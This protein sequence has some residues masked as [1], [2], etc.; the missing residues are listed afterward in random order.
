VAGSR[1][2]DYR[3]I[4]S[5]S[6]SND[7][8]LDLDDIFGCL[9]KNAKSVQRTSFHLLTNINPSS[10]LFKTILFNL[11]KLSELLKTYYRV[12]LAILTFLLSCEISTK[13]KIFWGEVYDP[14]TQDY[15]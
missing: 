14:P 10:R 1:N 11:S 4:L 15:P 2:F 12:F 9:T 8:F 5:F 7:S 6:F 3:M 13:L